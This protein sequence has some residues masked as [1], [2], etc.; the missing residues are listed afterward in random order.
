MQKAM[1][2]TF[3]NPL[4]LKSVTSQGPEAVAVLT[5]TDIFVV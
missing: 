4:N 2:V 1:N 3:R 5:L